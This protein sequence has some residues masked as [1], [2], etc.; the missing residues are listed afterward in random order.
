MFNDLSLE[1]RNPQTQDCAPILCTVWP[2][3]VRNLNSRQHNFSDF[4]GGQSVLKLDSKICEK[5]LFISVA[6]VEIRGVLRNIG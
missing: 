5:N 6:H 3:N 2:R 1:S 4:F